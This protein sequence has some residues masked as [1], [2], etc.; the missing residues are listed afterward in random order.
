MKR[1]L[2]TAAVLVG[3]S[4]AAAAHEHETVCDLGNEENDRRTWGDL[5]NDHTGLI[6]FSY[7]HTE[8]ER[9][10][11]FFYRWDPDDPESSCID[12][13]C[14]LYS[15]F[16]EPNGQGDGVWRRYSTSGSPIFQIDLQAHDVLQTDNWVCVVKDGRRLGHILTFSGLGQGTPPFPETPEPQVAYITAMPRALAGD[17]GT[18]DHWIRITNPDGKDITFTVTGRN[19]A[20]EEFGTYRR[21]LPAYRSVKVLM[22]HVEAAFNVSDPEG[23]WTLE[24]KGSGPIRVRATMF[25]QGIRQFVPVDQPR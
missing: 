10:V 1:G 18:P 24:V 12:R 9:Y 14:Q 4:G 22:R 3:L 8:P 16:S 20:G 11:Q 6:G 17:D 15:S 23:W 25:R 5:N 7:D 21:E 2:I 13:T 19:D